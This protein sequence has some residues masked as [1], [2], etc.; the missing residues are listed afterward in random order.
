MTLETAVR[1]LYPDATASDALF[2]TK[3]LGHPILRRF[4]TF[5]TQRE[6]VRRI[7]PTT[8]LGRLPAVALSY[9][10]DDARVNFVA[11]PH[12]IYERK[13]ELFQLHATGG[14]LLYRSL[15]GLDEYLILDDTIGFNIPILSALGSLP[16]YEALGHR[17]R[18][19]TRGFA[20]FRAGI[21]PQ[22]EALARGYL[23]DGDLPLA[24]RD[25]SAFLERAHALLSYH[26]TR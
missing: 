24:E 16:G 7:D 11:Y 4:V 20:Q 8:T 26:H 13:L 2:I 12:P 25:H 21:P 9:R 5:P 22:P 14:F 1:T 6:P 15:E 10:G 19:L 17:A 18:A 3:F 23:F